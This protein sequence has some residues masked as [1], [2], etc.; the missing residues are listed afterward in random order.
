M[1]ETEV[2]D[3]I[4]GMLANTDLSF[5]ERVIR[6]EAMM[7]IF[8]DDFTNFE[9]VTATLNLMNVSYLVS[10]NG[11]EIHFKSIHTQNNPNYKGYNFNV[12]L[13]PTTGTYQYY[14]RTFKAQNPHDTF[15][16]RETIKSCLNYHVNP[17]IFK[18]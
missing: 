2:S 5:E 4:H 7:K 16:V 15:S 1:N 14:T 8:Y 11:R 3:N 17:N 9:W 18:D 12:T 10:N 6:H 13:Y